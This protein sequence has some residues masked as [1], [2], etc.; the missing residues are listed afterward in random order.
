MLYLNQL[1]YPHIPYH[2]N[3]ANGGPLEGRDTVKTSGCGLCCAAMVVDRLTTQSLSIEEA[4]RLSEENGANLGIGTSMKI[5]G[6]IV[7]E[8]YGLDY[9]HTRDIR[10]AIAHLRRGGCVIVVVDGDREGYCGLFAKVAHYMVL[11]SYDGKEFC[12]LDP[13]LSETKYEEEGRVGRVRVEWPF[14][15]A[16]KEEI[17][18]A[19]EKRAHRYYLFSRKADQR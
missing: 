1:D 6:P 10:R 16:S 14:V 11:L 5:L 18:L 15:Y 3:M 13:S 17:M 8:R 9:A 12:I 19:T 2:H 4:V 7:A